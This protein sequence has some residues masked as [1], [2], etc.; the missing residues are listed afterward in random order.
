MGH[1]PG[2]YSVNTA[3]NAM[4]Q[5]AAGG[6]I[7]ATCCHPE[8]RVALVALNRTSGQHK[9]ASARTVANTCYGSH[10]YIVRATVFVVIQRAYVRTSVIQH[11]YIGSTD[12]KLFLAK[13]FNKY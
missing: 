4:N 13:M 7:D 2:S 3:A 11:I 6:Q 9:W 1:K 5:V 10:I 8:S 12:R